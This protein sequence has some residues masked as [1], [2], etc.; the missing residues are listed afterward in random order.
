MPRKTKTVAA[1]SDATA[2]AVTLSIRITP[3]LHEQML[4]TIEVLGYE[5]VDE[6]LQE[7]I[8]NNI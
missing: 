6:W 8:E 4:H 3:A 5:S 1:L 2:D 7:I